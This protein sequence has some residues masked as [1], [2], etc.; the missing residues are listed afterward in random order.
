M[1]FRRFNRTSIVVTEQKAKTWELDIGVPFLDRSLIHKSVVGPRAYKIKH[2]N[3]CRLKGSSF[4]GRALGKYSL[5]VHLALVEEFGVM[6][7]E[8]ATLMIHRFTR[9]AK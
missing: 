7:G 4:G 9:T 8:G 1:G 6:G 2:H 3:H 5:T